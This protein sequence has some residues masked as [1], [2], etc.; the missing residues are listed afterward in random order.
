MEVDVGGRQVRGAVWALLMG[1]GSG[2]GCDAGEGAGAADAAG[3]P[4]DAVVELDEGGPADAGPAPDAGGEVSDTGAVGVDAGVGAAGDGGVDVPDA[5]PGAAAFDRDRLLDVVV[6]IAPDDWEA[7]RVQSRG[8]LDFAGPD[9]LDEPF[10]SPYDWFPARVTV[11]GEVYDEVGIRKKGFYGSVSTSRPSVKVRFDK[12]VEGQ[13]HEGLTRLMLNNGRQDQS[14]LRTCLAYGVFA[15]YGVPAPRCNFARL[16]VN[17]EDFGVYAHVESLKRPFLAAHFGD[18]DG[19]LYEGTLSDFRPEWKGTMEQKTRVDERHTAGIDRVIAALDAP[20]DGLIEALD[21]AIDLESFL[22]FWAA[23]VLLGH[24]DGYSGNTNNFWFYEAPGDGRLRFIPWGPDATFQPPRL[25]YEGRLA[26]ESVSAVGAIT[27]RLYLHPVGRAR[28]LERLGELVDGW[29][30]GGLGAE[31]DR[32]EALVAPA[33]LPWERDGHA[34]AVGEVRAFVDGK[35][36]AVRAELAR[37]G[38]AWDVPLRRSLCTEPVGVF[39]GDFATTW[40][41]WPTDNVFEAGEGTFA[42]RY[43]EDEPVAVGVG[44]AAGLGEQGEGVLIISQF[45]GDGTITFVYVAA[46]V[47]RFAPGTLVVDDEVVCV[48]SYLDQRRGEVVRLGTCETGQVV[49]EAAERVEGAAVR[50]A[51]SLGVWGPPP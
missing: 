21:E 35:A 27:R 30:A 37:G 18:A 33:L 51:F 9:C 5:L 26:P 23:E 3:E 36:E 46:E 50:G 47:G 13:T 6:E 38:A 8:E 15:R 2:M 45:F 31:I 48:F 1:L 40:G 16:V 25:F 14:R 11:D 20:D 49:F 28:Y 43:Y 39:R 22:T 24:W 19:W 29:D 7:L 44:A 32:M 34:A 10:P 12:Y 17:G 42:G 4:G 41:A